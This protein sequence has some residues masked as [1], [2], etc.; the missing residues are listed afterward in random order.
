MDPEAN[1]DNRWQWKG[2]ANSQLKVSRLQISLSKLVLCQGVYRAFELLMQETDSH[3]LSNKQLWILAPLEGK[4]CTSRNWAS[5][6]FYFF[7]FCG[8]D[9]PNIVHGWK[10][11][12]AP[13]FSLILLCL[14][15]SSGRSQGCCHLI[16]SR[17]GAALVLHSQTMVITAAPLYLLGKAA[18]TDQSFMFQL[19]SDNF[20][21]S[22]PSPSVSHE[23]QI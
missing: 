19:Y 13:Q 16:F 8:L 15:N 20:W 12:P 2:L 17:W 22:I 6:E 5:I 21:F 18:P 4:D 11:P 7:P 9:T 3:F 23:P 14:T 10:I 1:Y